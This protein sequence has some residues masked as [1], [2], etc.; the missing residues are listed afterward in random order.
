MHKANARRTPNS[1]FRGEKPP[2]WYSRAYTLYYDTSSPFPH[3]SYVEKR[4]GRNV[5]KDTKKKKNEKKQQQKKA[6]RKK[7]QKKQ[8]IVGSLRLTLTRGV[9]ARTY[10]TQLQPNGD[11]TYSGASGILH[12]I[13]VVD[14]YPPT[15]AGSD[16]LV[17]LT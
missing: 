13:L 12:V 8:S 4:R 11:Q 5:I 14:L 10:R 2:F 17:C 3:N 1:T 7:D 6:K 15:R 9:C 16:S